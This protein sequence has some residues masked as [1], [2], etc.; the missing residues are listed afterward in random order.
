M[1]LAYQILTALVFCCTSASATPSA[2]F[3]WLRDLN[4]NPSSVSI[5]GGLQSSQAMSANGEYIVG[6]T[7]QLGISPFSVEESEPFLARNGVVIG[8]GVPSPIFYDVD[9]LI[10][11]GDVIYGQL[12]SIFQQAFS[13]RIDSGYE[14]ISD[15]I[16]ACSVDAKIHLLQ[17]QNDGFVIKNLQNGA[18]VELD[19]LLPLSFSSLKANSISANGTKVAGLLYNEQNKAVASFLWND[20]KP[21]QLKVIDLSLDAYTLL[22][23]ISPSG[24]HTYGS[25][26]SKNANLSQGFRFSLNDMYL[27][28]FPTIAATNTIF[29]TKVSTYNA[30]QIL[31]DRIS[32]IGFKVKRQSFFWSSKSGVRSLEEHLALNLIDDFSGEKIPTF[33]SAMSSNGDT[34]AGNQ[35]DYGSYQEFEPW[36]A[37]STKPSQLQMKV[38]TP[39]L[40]DLGSMYK[41]SVTIKNVGETK[42]SDIKLFLKLPKFLEI[43]QV[44]LDANCQQTKDFIICDWEAI[45]PG[46]SLTTKLDFLVRSNG[47]GYLQAAISSSRLPQKPENNQQTFEIATTGSPT[48]VYATIDKIEASSAE[49][50]RIKLSATARSF[51]GNDLSPNI[52][53]QIYERSNGL[54]E[55]FS[56]SQIEIEL[57]QG[58]YLAIAKVVDESKLSHYSKRLAFALD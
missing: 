56:G 49:I 37:K 9:S 1:R 57:S 3:V 55:E 46:T 50:S 31:G 34:L 45:T 27:E 36:I 33:V 17:T 35:A 29:D 5:I 48:E 7:S 13:Y 26:R 6:S 41:T 52:Q 58:Y 23:G 12:L 51:L 11:C 24:T 28:L 4:P 2:S 10:L 38:S 21:K 18:T 8:L 54:I 40:M 14:F 16:I 20:E 47:R 19:K 30:D 39:S 22:S 15:R 44:G 42:V 53:W 32:K 43:R 25:L